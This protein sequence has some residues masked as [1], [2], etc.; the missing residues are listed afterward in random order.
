MFCGKMHLNSLA[1][2]AGD[3]DL[4][5]IIDL[6]S[7]VGKS[8]AQIQKL[9]GTPANEESVKQGK[10]KTSW[11]GVKSKHTL[12]DSASTRIQP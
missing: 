8:A 7:I 12:S 9:L 4:E 3:L 2:E 11:N 1:F 10:K 6:P 5:V